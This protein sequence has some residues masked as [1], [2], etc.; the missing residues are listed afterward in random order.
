M[1]AVVVAAA[2]F[3]AVTA[4]AP[5]ISTPAGEV[6]ELAPFRFTRYR[7]LTWPG[8]Y[9]PDFNLVPERRWVHRFS[10]GFSHPAL[11]SWTFDLVGVEASLDPELRQ[12]TA[13]MPTLEG[14]GNLWMGARWTP[15]RSN[16]SMSF[17]RPLSV[18]SGILPIPRLRSTSSSKLTVHGRF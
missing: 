11:R 10:L 6:A 16:V 14:A 4:P 17:G 18:V 7:Q 9:L 8:T 5:A 1:C 3:V 13:G 12:R 2:L 15:K